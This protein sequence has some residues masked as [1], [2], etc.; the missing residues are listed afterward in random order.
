MISSIKSANKYPQIKVAFELLLSTFGHQ[1][2]W[3]GDSPWEIS[4]GAVLTQNT[5]WNNVEQAIANL[6]HR[7]LLSPK[8]ILDATT[9]DVAVAIRPSGFFNLKTARLK[10]LAK[11]WLDNV[12]NDNQLINSSISTNQLRDQLLAINGIGP[13]TADSIILY[14]FNIPTFVI[15]AYTRRMVSRHLDMPPDI[16]YNTLQNIF[17]SNLPES[18][19]LYN[20]YHALIVYNSKYH[21]KK[22]SCST[23]CPL[24]NLT[25]N[26]SR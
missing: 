7:A 26:V 4:V 15:D 18:T 9:E 25:S 19:Q 2:W 1:Y 17:I 16:N 5:N 11:W 6:K 8:L 22:N 23:S 14:A 12:K 21:C 10:N 24:H 20:E 13:E 3:P